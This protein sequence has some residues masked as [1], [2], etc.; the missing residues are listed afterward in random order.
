MFIILYLLSSD[1][2]NVFKVT[3]IEVMNKERSVLCWIY[4]GYYLRL[5][6]RD[7]MELE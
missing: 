1:R 6:K 3:R 4:T 7:V 2:F 5:L